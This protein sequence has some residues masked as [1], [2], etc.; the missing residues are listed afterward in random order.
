MSEYNQSPDPQPFL[1]PTSP[2]EDFCQTTSLIPVLY[3]YEAR[4]LLSANSEIVFSLISPGP[5]CDE[6]AE[7]KRKG[8]PKAEVQEL[9]SIPVSISL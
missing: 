8:R 1:L 3:E 5:M 6:P 2:S 9:R 4:A 7:G